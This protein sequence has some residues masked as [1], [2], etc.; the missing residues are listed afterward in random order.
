MNL[1]QHDQLSKQLNFV[2][3]ELLC[4]VIISKYNVRVW[5]PCDVCSKTNITS[6]YGI[7]TSCQDLTTQRGN[8]ALS[9]SEYTRKTCTLCSC[10]LYK[11][12]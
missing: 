5:I 12:L 11:L 7:F 3:G 1:N 8:M 10:S 6:K 9:L 2:H 4:T